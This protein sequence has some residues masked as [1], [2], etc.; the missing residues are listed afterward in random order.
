MDFHQ[1]LVE[2]AQTMGVRDPHIVHRARRPHLVGAVDG[3]TFVLAVPL[4]PKDIPENFFNS[5]R[6]LRRIVRSIRSKTTA[7]T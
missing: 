3:I 2:R 1:R 4:R 6:D 7:A 5:L